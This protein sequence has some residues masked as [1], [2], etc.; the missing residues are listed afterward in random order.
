MK[1]R[2]G[3]I[4]FAA[5]FLLQATLMNNIRI[6]GA[7]PNLLLCLTIVI[8]FLYDSG[9]T[10]IVL[11]VIFG[12]LYD[13]CFAQYS[14]VSSL[15]IFFVGFAVMLASDLMNKERAVALVIV[16]GAGTFL[17]DLIYWCIRAAMGTSYTFMHMLALQPLYICCNI[18]VALI[19]Y[20]IAIKKVVRHRQD[21]YYR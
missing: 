5:A 20:F 12:F 15:A 16:T 11:G 7:T 17:Y 18:P 1:Y 8:S 21:R 19:F 13:L 4:A 14:G 2:Y 6:F 9:F 10:G 3:V